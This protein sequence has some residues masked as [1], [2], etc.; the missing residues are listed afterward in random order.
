MSA[1]CGDE[2]IIGMEALG[3]IDLKSHELNLPVDWNTIFYLP[4]VLNYHGI[5]I[6]DRLVDYMCISLLYTCHHLEINQI[7]LL[8][9]HKGNLSFKMMEYNAV[10]QIKQAKFDF[11]EQPFILK[12]IDVGISTYGK[13]ILEERLEAGRKLSNKN[14]YTIVS[15]VKILYKK[16]SKGI[17]TKFLFEKFVDYPDDPFYYQYLKPPQIDEKQKPFIECYDKFKEY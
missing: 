16:F 15:F 14:N 10:Y 13:F 17:I 5:P 7:Q 2:L 9:I 6:T 1:F 11:G 12:L 3:P 4:L 8:D